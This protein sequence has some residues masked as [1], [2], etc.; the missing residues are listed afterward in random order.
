[1]STPNGASFGGGDFEAND[2]ARI[3]GLRAFLRVGRWLHL[4]LADGRGIAFDPIDVLGCEI[5]ADG[6]SISISLRGRE[7]EYIEEIDGWAIWEL[8]TSMAPHQVRR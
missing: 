2:P 5:S 6:R 4:R 1:M 7:S 3:E 8:L